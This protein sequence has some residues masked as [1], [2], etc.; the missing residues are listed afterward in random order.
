MWYSGE[1][2]Q[3]IPLD[4]EMF[5]IFKAS[6]DYIWYDLQFVEANVQLFKLCEILDTQRY[7]S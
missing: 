5:E 1:G 2:R 4:W 3:P 7:Y 6:Q